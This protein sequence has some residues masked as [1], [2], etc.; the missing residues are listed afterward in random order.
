M[1][2]VSKLSWIGGIF[3]AA[4]AFFLFREQ[5]FL[6]SAETASGT[7]TGLYSS[8]SS[9][10]GGGGLCPVIDFTTKDGQKVEYYGNVCTSPPVYRPGDTV[11]VVYDPQN[12]DKV[13]MKNFFSQYLLVLIF[14]IF[15]V[16]CIALWAWFRTPAKK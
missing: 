5:A 4:A 2:S 10:N 3:L 1:L 11:D 9:S 14:G 16:V 15:G 13:Q 6:G 12:V 8:S 7:V